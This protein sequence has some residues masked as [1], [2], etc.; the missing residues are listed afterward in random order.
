MKRICLVFTFLFVSLVAP[1]Q[2]QD[3]THQPDVEFN[4]LQV[5][6][7][8]WTY[9]GEYKSGPWG[10]ATKIKG[11]WMYEFVLNGF[12]LQGHC[13]EK[14][15]EGEIHYLEIAEFD[16]FAKNIADSVAGD[17]GSRYSGRIVFSG[18]TPIWI[19]T[20]VIGGKQYQFREPFELSADLMSATAKGEISEDGKTWM[21]F[22]EGTFTKVVPSVKK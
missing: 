17:D 5:L 16:S 8:H 19:E 3:A 2:S 1:A 18:K 20:F 21:P 10:P 4:K 13:T 22:F 15:S 7:G 11:E 6:V 14:S 9:N 12:I